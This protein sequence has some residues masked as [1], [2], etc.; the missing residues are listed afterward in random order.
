MLSDY[1]GR[2]RFA[3]L[4]GFMSL[5]MNVG[6]FISPYAAGR[7]ADLT[8]SYYI[9]LAV[10]TP[11]YL[12]SALAFLLSTR[13]SPPPSSRRRWLGAEAGASRQPAPAAPAATGGAG[14]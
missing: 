7:V 1:Y 2:A 11:L 8:G 12:V 4:M 10:F 6:M 5:F 9:I 13:P 3:T 14:N